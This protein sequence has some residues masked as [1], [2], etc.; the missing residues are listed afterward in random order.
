MQAVP[1]HPEV[2]NPKRSK[3]EIADLE[4]EFAQSWSLEAPTEL[5]DI[6]EAQLHTCVNPSVRSSGS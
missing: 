3:D 5:R 2:R 4:A 6:L 1:V